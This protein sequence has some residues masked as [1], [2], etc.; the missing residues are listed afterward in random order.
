ML[1]CAYGCIYVY[2]AC[3]RLGPCVHRSM[4]KAG[5]VWDSK[6]VVERY[7]CKGRREEG[8]NGASSRQKGGFAPQKTP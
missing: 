4:I 7:L 8:R 3:D 5:G 1:L 6:Q 2:V